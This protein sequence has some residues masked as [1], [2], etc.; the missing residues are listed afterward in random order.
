MGYLTLVERSLSAAKTQ[1]LAAAKDATYLRAPGFTMD[2]YSFIEPANRVCFG[3]ER[4]VFINNDYDF[5]LKYCP[6][7]VRQNFSEIHCW[8]TR[9]RIKNLNL[10]PIY[11]HSSDYRFL[12]MQKCS[13][14]MIPPFP[15][16][17][18]DMGQAG[19]IE[20][21]FV[22]YDYG[23]LLPMLDNLS[24]RSVFGFSG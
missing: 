14:G 5:V 13:V 24:Y 9:D 22:A 3:S 12:C 16:T 2:L 18:L 6:D 7:S 21:K 17:L 19:T 23:T 20:G 10:A 4:V 15:Y 1:A 11:G 8:N